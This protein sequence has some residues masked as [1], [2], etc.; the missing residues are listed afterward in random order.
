MVASPARG[1]YGRVC[2]TPH[3]PA[4]EGE[5]MSESKEPETLEAF[6]EG[7]SDRV[8]SCREL[9]HHWRPLTVTWE[10][11]ARAYHR[12]M[13]CPGCRTVRTQVLTES[14]H[15]LSNGYRYPDGY[16]A[17][18]VAERINRDAF[19]MEAVQRFLEQHQPNGEK[20]A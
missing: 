15:V 5:R 12:Q 1:G 17:S 10:P 7:L 19:R 6:V 9:G 18:G 20:V 11:E 14:G 8:L 2:K 3:N 16:L 13:R 4:R